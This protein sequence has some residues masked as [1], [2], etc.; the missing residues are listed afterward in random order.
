MTRIRTFAIATAAMSCLVALSPLQPSASHRDAPPDPCVGSWAGPCAFL[1][2]K[3][4]AQTVTVAS[5]PVSTTLGG[6]GYCWT[7]I[8]GE[9]AATFEATPQSG[10]WLIKASFVPTLSA[11][12]SWAGDV[13]GTAK[14]STT[15]A[16]GSVGSLTALKLNLS[17]AGAIYVY[18]SLIVDS[19]GKVFVQG[20]SI[21]W[22]NG[23]PSCGGSQGHGPPGG[24]D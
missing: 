4:P 7:V 9:L 13:G 11:T 14:G 19:R 1:A 3:P 15:L 23:N 2:G 10:G 20:Y 6:T 18:C 12:F 8:Q 5:L 24:S 17:G 16:V 22:V 21:G